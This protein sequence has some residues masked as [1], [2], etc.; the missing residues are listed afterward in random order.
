MCSLRRSGGPP[1]SGRQWGFD[2][3]STHGILKGS[4][5]QQLHE[6]IDELVRIGLLRTAYVTKQFGGNSKEVTFAEY[7]MTEDG[8]R[9]MRGQAD[10]VRPPLS[11]PLCFC[12]QR[13]IWLPSEEAHC[14]PWA[15]KR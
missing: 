8:D 9:V 3:L 13:S 2:A 5:S 6:L 11:H 1:K 7:S 4:D 10:P 14:Q 15:F 12:V